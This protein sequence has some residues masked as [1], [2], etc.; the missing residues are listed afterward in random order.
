MRPRL[1][2]ATRVFPAVAVVQVQ[3]QLCLPGYRREVVHQTLRLLVG[4][5]DRREV[6]ASFRPV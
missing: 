3:G 4:E 1:M 6:V 5:D 2:V